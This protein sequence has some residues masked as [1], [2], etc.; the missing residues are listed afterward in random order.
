MYYTFLNLALRRERRTM[1]ANLWVIAK[2]ACGLLEG[3]GDPSG[4]FFCSDA[5]V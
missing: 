1:R 5:L 4:E 3:F 2:T